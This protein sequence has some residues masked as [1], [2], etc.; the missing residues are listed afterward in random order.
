M[1][2]RSLPAGFLWDVAKDLVDTGRRVKVL[3]Q[4]EDSPAFIAKGW[5]YRSEFHINPSHELM[6]QIKGRPP[7]KGTVRSRVRTT[8]FDGAVSL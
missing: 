4:E 8:A 3:W 7:N 6:Y 1:A 5:D 2:W